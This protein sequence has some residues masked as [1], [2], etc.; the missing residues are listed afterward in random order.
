MLHGREVT[1]SERELSIF[2]PPDGM[3][4][5]EYLA[6]LAGK[7]PGTLKNPEAMLNCSYCPFKVADEFLAGSR[8]YWNDRWRNYG[9]M[10]AFI[11]FN[12]AVAIFVY[13]MFRVRKSKAKSMHFSLPWSKKNDKKEAGAAD[14]EKTSATEQPSN[15]S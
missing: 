7:A 12:I 1:C 14:T 5:G 15:S 13:Y 8:I 4:C 2:N 9:I 11:C 3:T 10:W 6:P